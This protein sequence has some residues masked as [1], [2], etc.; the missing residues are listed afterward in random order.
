MP[1]R[2]Q[3]VVPC[4]NEGDRLDADAFLR[5]IGARPDIGLVFVDD[6]SSDRTPA[7]L[8]DLATRGGAGVAVLTLQSNGGKGRAVQ[9]GLGA[10]F[11]RRPEFVGYWDADLSTPLGAIPDFLAIFDA[12]PEVE[13]VMGARVKLLGRSIT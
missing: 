5:F 10:A 13:I 1:A 8:A 6:G 9:R 2:V 3:L 4:Y 12:R 7:I 11:E